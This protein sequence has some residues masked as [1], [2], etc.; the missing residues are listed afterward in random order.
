MARVSIPLLLSDVT[1]GVRQAEVAGTTLA[2]V[3]AALEALHPGIATRICNGEK[4]TPNV[5]VTVDGKIA[6]RGLATPVRP[7]SQVA[8]LPAFG[9]G[10]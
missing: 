10:T 8:I 6:A 2:E 3:V 5:A 4:I 1:G 9:G 7:E